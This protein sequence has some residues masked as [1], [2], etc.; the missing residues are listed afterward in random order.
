[1][2][3]IPGDNAGSALPSG[4]GRLNRVSTVAGFHE[5]ART[6]SFIRVGTLEELQAKGMM[7]VQGTQ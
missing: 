4:R 1:L 2:L 6:D 7:V 5:Q 3:N